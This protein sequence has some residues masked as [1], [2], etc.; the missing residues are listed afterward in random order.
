MEKKEVVG[1]LR[2]I[3]AVYP[4]FELSD[5]LVKVWIDLMKDVSYTE[6]FEKLKV[7]CKTNKFP[8]K[9]AELLYEEKHSGPTL[10]ETKQLFKQWDEESEDI[11]TP[12]AKAKHLKEIAKLLGIRRGNE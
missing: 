7:H 4:H 11:A 12:E 9:P 1:L 8:P 3:V 2:Y 5:D 10:N 6:T